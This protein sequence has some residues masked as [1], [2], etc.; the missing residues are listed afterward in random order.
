[1][2]QRYR[3]MAQVIIEYS[4]AVRAGDLVLIRGLSPL[5]EPLVQMLYSEAMAREAL[6][7]NYLHI[8]G[9]DRLA[10]EATDNLGLLAE[11][12]PMLVDMYQ[13]ADVIIGIQAPDRF[14]DLS[15]Y[16]HRKQHARSVANDVPIRI[17]K[18]RPS[19]RRCTAL[20]PTQVHAQAADMSLPEFSDFLFRACKVHLPDPVRAWQQ[21]SRRQSQL[22]NYLSGKCS[23]TVV[24]AHIELTMAIKDRVFINSAGKANFPDGEVFT[25][26]VE[27]SVEGWVHFPRA[28]SYHGVAVAGI[29]LQFE[30]GKVVKA[31]AAQNEAYL[32][33]LLNRDVGARY[34][35][36]FGIGMNSDVDRLTGSTLLDEKMAGSIHLALGQG[37]PDAGGRNRSAIHWDLVYDLR[38]GAELWVDGQLISVNGLLIDL[39]SA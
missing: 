15:H 10:I 29:E 36:E 8:G 9:E 12:N 2:D 37:F 6:P 5:A 7:F 30:A 21:L 23:V 38:D 34:M 28:A 11:P 19:V 35:G 3:S 33:E 4:T 32:L 20:V 17:Q 1:M 14:S 25:S 16:P 31:T 22:V 26:P 13:R 24:G 39:P 27:E 18:G